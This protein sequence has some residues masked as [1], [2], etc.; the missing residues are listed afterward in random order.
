MSR[1]VSKQKFALMSFLKHNPDAA[2]DAINHINLKYPKQLSDKHIKDLPDKAYVKI[3]DYLNERSAD[4]FASSHEKASKIYN[5]PMR[6]KRRTDDELDEIARK[7]LEKPVDLLKLEML[8]A[9]GNENRRRHHSYDWGTDENRMHNVRYLRYLKH[10][11]FDD[12]VVHELAYDITTSLDTKR[13]KALVCNFKRA[14]FDLNNKDEEGIGII[15]YMLRQIYAREKSRVSWDTAKKQRQ[16]AKTYKS[17]IK[18]LYHNGVD[19]RQEDIEFAKQLNNVSNLEDMSEFLRILS[20]TQRLWP[21]DHRN[22]SRHTT[23]RGTSDSEGT[24]SESEGS[25]KSGTESD[26]SYNSHSGRYDD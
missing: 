2:A 16:R 21:C 7:H 17:K 6:L 18:W 1:E 25:T 3:L 11:N 19:I 13:W 24:S 10:L 12:N 9:I 8:K 14:N 22:Q 4:T 20:Q 26:T 5:V 15:E 23:H